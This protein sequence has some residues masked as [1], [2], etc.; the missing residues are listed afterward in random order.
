MKGKNTIF[1][2]SID[3]CK[4]FMIT[5][6]LSPGFCDECLNIAIRICNIMKNTPIYRSISQADIF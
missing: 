1:Y 5:Q 4:A 2:F 6:M 3:I